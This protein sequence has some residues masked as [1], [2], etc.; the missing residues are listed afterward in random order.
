MAGSV[1]ATFILFLFLQCVTHM[2]KEVQL[3]LVHLKEHKIKL[4]LPLCN[5]G[6]HLHSQHG[7]DGNISLALLNYRIWT[8]LQR[9]IP[10][11]KWKHALLEVFL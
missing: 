9:D 2:C 8:H 10:S 1:V 11:L 7:N 6:L 3:Q 5:S 4:Q